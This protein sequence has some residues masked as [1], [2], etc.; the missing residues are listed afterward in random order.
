MAKY[1]VG[2]TVWRIENRPTTKAEVLEVGEGPNG[3]IYHISYEEGGDGWRPE[4][5]L[6]DTSSA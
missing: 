3:F 1:E 4:D 6:T 5:S 2:D